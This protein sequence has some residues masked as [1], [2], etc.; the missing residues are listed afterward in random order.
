MIVIDGPSRIRIPDI[1]QHEFFKD[2][3][4]TCPIIPTSQIGALP[5]EI[6][7]M[8]DLEIAGFDLDLIRHSVER[9]ASDQSSALW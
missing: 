7:L 8:H 3:E 2:L 5:D 1:L 9:S 4:S 6:K